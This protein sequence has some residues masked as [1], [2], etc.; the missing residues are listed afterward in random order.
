[1]KSEIANIWC[2][3]SNW[4]SA[5]P[6]ARKHSQGSRPEKEWTHSGTYRA[7]SLR[8]RARRCC[9]TLH[10]GEDAHDTKWIAQQWVACGAGAPGGSHPGP[11]P[12]AAPPAAAPGPTGAA[13]EELLATR[14]RPAGK[15]A[16]Q[17]PARRKGFGAR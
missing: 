15:K 7:E 11:A 3:A 14:R 9:R 12:A 17:G 4:H 6:E 1:M 5:G 8:A 16:A 10:Q 2:A 13:F